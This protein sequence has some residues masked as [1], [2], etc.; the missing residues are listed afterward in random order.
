M[1]LD[2]P[3]PDW[4]RPGTPSLGLQVRVLL[5]ML[6]LLMDVQWDH[7][8]P[9]ERRKFDTEANDTIPP[10]NDPEH[11]EAITPAEH[12]RRSNGPGGEQRITTA[13]SDS[14]D[15]AKTRSIRESLA[16]FNA[17]IAAKEA[18][19]PRPERRGHRLRSRGFD[20]TKT[21]TMRGKVVPRKQRRRS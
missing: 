20:K 11:I 3:P 19:E 15:R 10:A 6:G 16:L 14:N 13:G 7:R 9:L 17:R 2:R 5:R 1:I 4:K 18:G 8:P 12:D 21:R